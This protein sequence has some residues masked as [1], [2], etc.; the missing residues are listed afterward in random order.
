[1]VHE[2]PGTAL[3][4]MLDARARRERRSSRG[5]L[6]ASSALI[7][8]SIDFSAKPVQAARSIGVSA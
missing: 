3:A 6:L 4:D 5:R 2:Q 8:F 1:V 7:R